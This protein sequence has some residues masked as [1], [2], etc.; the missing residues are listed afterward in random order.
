MHVATERINVNTRGESD[1]IDITPELAALIEKIGFKN[2]IAAVF[3]PGA[4]GALSTIEYEPGAVKDLKAAFERIAPREGHYAHN[5]KWGDGNGFS[6]VRASVMGPSITVPVS[7]GRMT[8][9]TWQQVIFMDF[10]NRPRSREIVVQF[11]GER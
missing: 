6:H 1:V 9:G 4:T 7:G 3:V 5:T 11:L 2:G 10:D 8:L